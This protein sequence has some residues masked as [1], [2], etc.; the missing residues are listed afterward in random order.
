MASRR[1]RDEQSQK[2]VALKSAMTAAA[3]AAKA[4]CSLP[5]APKAKCIALRHILADW[6]GERG[7][8]SP[9]GRAGRTGRVS[10]GLVQGGADGDQAVHGGEGQQAAGLGTGDDQPDLAAFGLGSPVR[11]DQGVQSG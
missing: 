7:C 3:P 11:A 10:E 8:R 6:P 2:V 1:R 4:A 9:P 5:A